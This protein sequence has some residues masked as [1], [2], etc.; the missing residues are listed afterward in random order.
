MDVSETI[1]KH[2]RKE[3]IKKRVTHLWRNRLKFPVE[4]KRDFDELLNNISKEEVEIANNCWN[5]LET[6][7]SQDKQK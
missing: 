5:K 2:E 1:V 4:T 6:E 7:Y 3:W